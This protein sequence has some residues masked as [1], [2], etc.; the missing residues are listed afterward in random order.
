MFLL[1]GGVIADRFPRTL[2]LQLS[3]LS[4]AA[5]Q[6]MIAFL[7]ITDT[8]ELWMLITLS[9]VHGLV[10]AISFPAMASMV[11]QL[12]PRDA[13]PAAPTPCCRSRAAA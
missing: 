10:S 8:A 9:A 5:T 2:V 3:N 4:S 6:G 7:V 13:A 12:V 11:P 1:F